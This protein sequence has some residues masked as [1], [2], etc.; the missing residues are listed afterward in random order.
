MKQIV[1]NLLNFYQIY[2]SFDRGILAVFAPG[3]ACK[4]Y[5]TCSE[6]TKE[7]VREFGVFRGS[8]LGL[9]R[10]WGCK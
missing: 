4:G 9:Q 5:P 7:K 10:I 8:W 3:G 1:L 2:L 6:Y